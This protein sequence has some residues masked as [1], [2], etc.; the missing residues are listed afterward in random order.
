[1]KK[2][3][4]VAVASAALG[5]LATQAFAEPQPNMKKALV[6]L[7]D[8]KNHLEKAT[9]DKGGHRVKAMALITDAISEVKA[10]IE[11]DNKR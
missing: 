10:G 2:M 11:F 8:A 9:A 3:L 6:S 1:M 7:E 5:G 4:F